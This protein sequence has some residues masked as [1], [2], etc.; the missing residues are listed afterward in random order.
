[1]CRPALLLLAAACLGFAPAPFM[2]R[3]VRGDLER[4]QGVWVGEGG[5][6]VATFKG[7]TLT[8]HRNGSLIRTYNLTL[9]TDLSPRGYDL[10]EPGSRRDRLHFKGVYRFDG[11]DTLVM[12]S[13][14]YNDP[15][16]AGFAVTYSGGELKTL[17]RRR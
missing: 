14:P 17:M 3:P 8:Y 4:L 1:M 9:H 5:A 7:N 16:P 10:D 12:C 11:D 13:S 6:L 15:R 2:P